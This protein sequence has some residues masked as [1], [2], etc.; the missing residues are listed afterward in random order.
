MVTIAVEKFAILALR[1]TRRASA[2]K[3]EWCNSSS[4]GRGLFYAVVEEGGKQYKVKP[5]QTI[6]VE[7]LDAPLGGEV[8]LGRVLLVSG[9][10]GVR[11]GNPYLP[12]AKVRATVTGQD[13]ARKVLVFKYRPRVRYRRKHGHRQSY[14]QLAIG[15]IVTG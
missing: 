4:G 5:G 10:D 2:A 9:E 6:R 1:L 11:M 15:E 7:K 12:G 13:R 14:T 3:I 8:E